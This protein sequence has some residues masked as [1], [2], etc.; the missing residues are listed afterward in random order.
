MLE[1][2]KRKGWS[3]PNPTPATASAA[4]RNGNKGVIQVHYH[5]SDKLPVSDRS[6]PSRVISAILQDLYP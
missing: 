6:N 4:N 3:S 5:V 2:A 1:T